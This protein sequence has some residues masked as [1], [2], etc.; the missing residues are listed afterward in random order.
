MQRKFL[1]LFLLVFLISLYGCEDSIYS[2]VDNNGSYIS[3]QDQLDFSFISNKCVPVV[4]Y[5]DSVDISGASLSRDDAFKYLCA[6]L[7]CNGF[8]IIGG[9]ETISEKGT[10]DMYNVVASILGISPVT[11]SS[12]SYILPEYMKSVTICNIR[13][14]LAKDNNTSLDKSTAAVCGLSGMIDSAIHISLL[15]SSIKGEDIPIEISKDGFKDALS[16]VNVDKAIDNFLSKVE[17]ETYLDDLTLALNIALESIEPMDNL[18]DGSASMVN[19]IK[20]SL[21]DETTNKVTAESLK[22]YIKSIKDGQN[23]HFKVGYNN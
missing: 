5:Y 10:S 12:L 21:F 7:Y 8:D 23:N 9:I 14:M 2:E 3:K 6:I 16:L 17:N 22:L 18:L 4:A 19:E 1:Y 20:N 15:I 13:D 11:S